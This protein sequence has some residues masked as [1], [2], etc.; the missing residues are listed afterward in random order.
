[1]RLHGTRSDWHAAEESRQR[2]FAQ[3]LSIGIKHE[4]SIL[5]RIGTDTLRDTSFNV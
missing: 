3:Q 5:W 4:W 2:R 1:M